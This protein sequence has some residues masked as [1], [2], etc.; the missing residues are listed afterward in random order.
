M[1][2]QHFAMEQSAVNMSVPQRHCCVCSEATSK[3]CL[4]CSKPLHK[5]CSTLMKNEE[6]FDPDIV[7]SACAP[8]FATNGAFVQSDK[9]VGSATVT[10]P[11][12]LAQPR[13]VPVLEDSD[14]SEAAETDTDASL[15]DHPRKRGKDQRPRGKKIAWSPALVEDLCRLACEALKV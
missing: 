10:Q 6:T 13:N 8:M 2:I 1:L 11:P 9:I 5:I 3:S 14:D 4:A 7:C 15:D 12:V